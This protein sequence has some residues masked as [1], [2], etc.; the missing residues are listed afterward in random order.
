MSFPVDVKRRIRRSSLPEACLIAHEKL[1]WN[2]SSLSRN[3]SYYYWN[4]W[5]NPGWI[6]K[7]NPNVRCCFTFFRC[8]ISSYRHILIYEIES[9]R[10]FL[11]LHNDCIVD[12]IR[13]RCGLTRLELSVI[14]LS[15]VWLSSLS[16]LTYGKSLKREI[17]QFFF[18]LAL[19]E[20]YGD[21]SLLFH[22]S[23]LSLRVL[24]MTLTSKEKSRSI[25]ST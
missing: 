4:I 10:R 16:R 19:I 6:L 17:P 20:L 18:L 2:S 24:F 14:I 13:R 15:S 8:L 3:N 1:Y 22:F 9:N 12:Y 11:S 7:K 23:I 5:R 21:K 25:L